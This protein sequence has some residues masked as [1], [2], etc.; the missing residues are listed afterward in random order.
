[1]T[2]RQINKHNKYRPIA[3]KTSNM[4]NVTTA[5]P[6]NLPVLV[7]SPVTQVTHVTQLP[8]VTQL[9]ARPDTLY[10]TASPF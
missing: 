2:S 3:P 1:M 7:S 10:H 8:P 5:S 6:G 4:S 9:T